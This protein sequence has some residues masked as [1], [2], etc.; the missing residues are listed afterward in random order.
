VLCYNIQYGFGTDGKNDLERIAQVINECEPDVVALQEVDVSIDRSGN[1][2]QA[3]RLAELT[4]M[5]AR[6]GPAHDSLGGLYG[7]AILTRFPIEDV[8]IQP[9]PYTPQ[10]TKHETYPRVALAVTVKAPDGQPLRVVSTHFQHIL[11]Q[12]RLAQAKAINQ[13]FAQDGIRTILAGDLNAVPGSPPVR[14]LLKHWSYVGEAPLAPTSPSQKP[15]RRIDYIMFTPG[16]DL[17]PLGE[18][19]INEP[20]ASDH[21]PLVADFALRQAVQ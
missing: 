7:N 13:H 5:Q 17:T 2:H 4:G 1:V 16:E 10:S 11:P 12:D 18:Q 9:L 6:Y 21:C 14:E 20:L 8:W 19:V 15:R 3:R